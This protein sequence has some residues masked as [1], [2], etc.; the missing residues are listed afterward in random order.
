MNRCLSPPSYA[1]RA[2]PTYDGKL[3]RS[4]SVSKSRSPSPFEGGI[5]FITS[6]AV[7]GHEYD[8]T[9]LAHDRGGRSFNGGSNT[10]KNVLGLARDHVI[11]DLVLSHGLPVVLVIQDHVAG[12]IC[13]E[14]LEGKGIARCR[15]GAIEEYLRRL[16]Q[17]R[18]PHDPYHLTKKS[19]VPHRPFVHLHHP[20]Q[21]PE[22]YAI[23]GRQRND[24]DSSLSDAESTSPSK[25]SASCLTSKPSTSLVTGSG[26]GPG[27]TKSTTFSPQERLKRKMKAALNKQY[28]A[29]KR[30]EKEKLQKAEQERLR[31]SKL[32]KISINMSQSYGLSNAIQDPTTE[33][34]GMYYDFNPSNQ[35]KISSTHTQRPNHAIQFNSRSFIPPVLIN[36]V[37]EPKPFH[38]L[39][40][41]EKQLFTKELSAI[42]GHLSSKIKWSMSGELSSVTRSELESRGII[43]NVPLINAEEDLLQL[44]TDQ[45]VKSVRRFYKQGPDGAKIPLTTVALTFVS[46]TFP[47]E[48]VIAHELF[49]IK[50]Y[51]PRPLICY[52]CSKIGHHE[53]TCE[54][55]QNCRSC[56]APHDKN[57]DCTDTSHCATC[58]QLDHL[59]GMMSCPLYD[60]RQEAI[61]CAYEQNISIPEAIR[62]LK[63]Q[64]DITN[65]EEKVSEVEVEIV[66]LKNQIKPL[67][68]FPSTGYEMKTSTEKGFKATLDELN[69]LTD[70]L[71]AGIIK[72]TH[73]QILQWNA[74]G[75]FRAKLQEFRENLRSVNPIFV[76]LSETHW[77]NEYTI[78]FSADNSYLLNRPGQGGGVAILVKKAIQ[79]NILTLPYL[80]NLEAVGVSVKLNYSLIDLISVYCPNGN[81]CNAQEINLL[82]NTPRNKAIIGGDFNVHS[83]HTEEAQHL[84]KYPRLLKLHYRSYFHHVGLIPRGSPLRADE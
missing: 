6:F 64:D 66:T 9:F 31:Y 11:V 37:S 15:V 53:S 22:K 65:L 46:S 50:K 77:K 2:S 52:K 12:L 71:K 61:K 35:R 39:S 76:F 84:S 49:R 7:I 54:S 45:G 19:V 14:L 60:E 21:S 26:R 5:K 38:L 58:G 51:I 44:I 33:A 34:E 70:F 20:P 63:N 81:Q 74:R 3:L 62:M 79:T 75:L 72:V 67:L 42:I 25:P 80:P 27:A 32:C 68:F 82:F 43:H 13:R 29:D 8:S 56:A 57:S 10:T 47:P 1:T 16:H 23:I 36:F 41:V 24:S 83:E 40:F 17:T 18:R 28:K 78:K 4:K 48:V 73:L 59:A 55:D 30:A 69:A